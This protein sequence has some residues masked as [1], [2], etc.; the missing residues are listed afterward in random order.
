LKYLRLAGGAGNISYSPWRR[1]IFVSV[2][3]QGEKISRSVEETEN[4]LIMQ[5]RSKKYF[6]P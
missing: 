4:I 6:Y 1:K 2:Q 5:G 3:G